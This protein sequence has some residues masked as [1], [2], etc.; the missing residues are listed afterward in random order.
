V[1]VPAALV[2][3]VAFSSCR[4]I[5]PPDAALIPVE[6]YELQGV[7]MSENG[8]PLSGVSVYLLYSSDY[9]QQT[10]S[11]TQ[12]VVVTRTSD[13][14]DVAAVDLQDHVEKVLF[15]G[16]LTSPGRVPRY[17]WDGVDAAGH[18]V[19][20]GEY[21]IRYTVGSRVVKRS[22]VI[23]DGH[24]TAVSDIN[25]RFTIASDH[26]PVDVVYDF[27]TQDSVFTGAFIIRPVIALFF[28]SQG[29]RASYPTVVLTSN[30]VTTGVFVL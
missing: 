20:S 11:D 23:I 2:I 25:G 4:D 28:Q 9:Y 1:R 8:V 17:D 6:G 3:L 18:D 5:Q 19:P 26:L 30:H 21:L 10:P 16:T 14:V 29:A 15:H 24:L 12:N 27:Y 13:I 7:V 22:P